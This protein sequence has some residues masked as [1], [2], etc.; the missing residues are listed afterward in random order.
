M[1][2]CVKAS[3]V[4]G[5]YDARVVSVRQHGAALKRRRS[6]E[7]QLGIGMDEATGIIRTD[8][9]AAHLG[10]EFVLIEEGHA[11]SRMTLCEK[12]LNFMGLIHGGAIFS[13][14]D[15]TFG[16]AAN[17]NGTKAMAIHVSIDYLAP[18]GD[19][20]YLEADV[21]EDARAGKGG[22]YHMEV[23]SA[24]GEIVAVCNGWAYHT[25]RPLRD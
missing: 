17:S 14:A 25:A 18:P 4:C 7:R 12:H 23:R 15:A 6:R 13:L 16:A 19:T 20:P 1:H 24:A 9:Y 21:R 10:I 11:V 5:R 22:H 3:A 8:P 2:L